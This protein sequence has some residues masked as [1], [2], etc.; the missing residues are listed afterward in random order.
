MGILA[1][2]QHTAGDTRRWMVRYHKWLDNTATIL[3]ATVTS[4]SPTCTI[5]E[6]TVLGKDVQ[7]YTLDGVEGEHFNV[8]IQMTDSLDNVKTDTITFTVVPP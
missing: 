1:S 6:I 5:G 3:S 2:R 4:P 8:R 7:F